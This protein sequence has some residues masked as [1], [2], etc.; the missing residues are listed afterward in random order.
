MRVAY[1]PS[2]V[3]VH[4]GQARS[5]TGPG[6]ISRCRTEIQIDDHGRHLFRFHCRFQDRGFESRDVL[7]AVSLAVTVAALSKP[8][9]VRVEHAAMYLS[10]RDA[11]RLGCALRTP[12]AWPKWTVAA[13][14]AEG[15][16]QGDNDLTVVLTDTW[17]EVCPQS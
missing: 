1:R 6:W 13:E 3:G 14:L 7:L 2:T 5:G 16:P 8:I 4:E 15:D 12:A 9:A 10:R 17:S 11:M